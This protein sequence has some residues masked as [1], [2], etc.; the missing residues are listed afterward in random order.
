MGFYML[1]FGGVYG[2]SSLLNLPPRTITGASHICLLQK[3]TAEAS[4]KLTHKHNTHTHMTTTPNKQLL[5]QLLTK[6]AHQRPCLEFG[7]YGDVVAYR[8][9]IRLIGLQLSDARTLLRA[10]EGSGITAEAIV[11][12]LKTGRL[13]LRESGEELDF[14]AGQYWPSEYRAAVCRVCSDILWAYI[15]ASYPHFDGTELRR[16]FSRWFGKGLQKRWFN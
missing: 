13:N 1:H 7:N 2:W 4:R 9:E 5:I 10:L 12:R 14:C 11:D 6:W 16:Y 3:Q 8:A 15:R